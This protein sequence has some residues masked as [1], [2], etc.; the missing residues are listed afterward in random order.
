M[1]DFPLEEVEDC[2]NIS[3]STPVTLSSLNA[4]SNFPLKEVEAS[5]NTPFLV[6]PAPD[7]KCRIDG[8][9][10]KTIF[11]N[12]Y[13][14]DRH[15][16]EHNKSIICTHQTCGKAFARE[17]AMKKHVELMHAGTINRIP[18]DDKTCLKSFTIKSNMRK[19][20]RKFHTGVHKQYVSLEDRKCIP[21]ADKTCRQKFTREDNME[22]HVRKYHIGVHNQYLLLKLLG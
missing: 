11:V 1:F 6:P 13:N 17:W 16:K 7:W 4:E 9:R 21:C 12:G 20:F 3:S 10:S 18:C 5:S 14:R 8:C 19:H 2:F 22:S 15:E